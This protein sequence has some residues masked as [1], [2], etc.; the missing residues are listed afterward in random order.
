[1]G[2]G[3]SV[4]P[5]SVIWTRSPP[6]WTGVHLDRP[7]VGSGDRG[8]RSRARDRDLLHPGPFGA[9]APEWLGE[10]A[11]PARSRRG[12]P[13]STTSRA[14]CRR[15]RARCDEPVR[16]VV[17][18][19]VLDHVL[20]H[21]SQQRL[22]A[23]SRRSERARFAPG[24]A[25]GDLLVAGGER[26]VGDLAQRDRRPRPSSP[27]CARASV[28]K[29][30]S[31][32]SAWSSW[33]RRFAPSAGAAPARLGFSA[34]DIEHDAHR[35]ERCAQ[36]MRGV[37]DEPPRDSNAAS[38]RSSSPS[39]VSASC[40]SSSRGPR[41]RAVRA[42]SLRDP[43]W[44]WRSSPAKVAARGQQPASRGLETDRHGQRDPR[45]HDQLV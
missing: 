30:S 20:D 29:L 21:R 8:R 10:L 33:S 37:R 40:V 12:P 5:G 39:I 32:R 24:A 1:M 13:L 23:R 19:G 16:R 3:L 26:V 9:Q 18:H 11:T 22:G 36:L 31:S 27:R 2:R 28:R 42:G 7:A 35:R 14:C 45:L 25:S 17:E 4:A 41:S 34:R 6:L 15:V 43:R 38:R 44:S